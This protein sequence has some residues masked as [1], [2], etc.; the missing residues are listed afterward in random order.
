MVSSFALTAAV[1]SAGAPLPEPPP[2][3]F[4]E[5]AVRPSPTTAA[6]AAAR[7]KSFIASPSTLGPV[8]ADLRDQRSATLT[9]PLTLDLKRI[10]AQ[11]ARS[12]TSS[13][14]QPS[15]EAGPRLPNGPDAVPY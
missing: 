14:P 7:T 9:Q 11:R 5:Q 12:T 2:V 15:W 4:A 6:T 13:R 3:L 1:P 10:R 8:L